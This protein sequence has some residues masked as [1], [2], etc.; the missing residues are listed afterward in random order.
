MNCQELQYL[1]ELTNDEQDC[2]STRV[3]CSSST[4]FP[5]AQYFGHLRKFWLSDF[6]ADIE[7][8]KLQ[9]LFTFRQNFSKLLSIVNVLGQILFGMSSIDSQPSFNQLKQPI[10]CVWNSKHS[11]IY[12]LVILTFTYYSPSL[13]NEGEQQN[14]EARSIE[15]QLLRLYRFNAM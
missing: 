8:I 3:H 5:W 9:S 14:F 6:S 1:F 11:Y 12:I 7:Q 2:S 13:K 15:I 4:K 10:T